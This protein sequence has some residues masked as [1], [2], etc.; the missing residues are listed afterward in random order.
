M[1]QFMELEVDY[2][3]TRSSLVPLA[4]NVIYG[5]HLS[6]LHKRR[7]LILGWSARMTRDDGSRKQVLIIL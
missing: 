1:T 5:F 3:R 7:D 2:H 4:W 6:L